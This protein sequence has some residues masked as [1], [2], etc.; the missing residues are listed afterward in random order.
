MFVK[1]TRQDYREFITI[2]FS[3]SF[4]KSAL[5]LL[6]HKRQVYNRTVLHYMSIFMQ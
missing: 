5:I 6:N 2:F 1:L 3:T 4:V